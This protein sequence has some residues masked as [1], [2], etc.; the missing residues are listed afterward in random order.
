MKETK[1]GRPEVHLAVHQR[2]AAAKRL[3]HR[4][5]GGEIPKARR[6]PCDRYVNELKPQTSR[7]VVLISDFLGVVN[8]C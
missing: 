1:N 8:K 3:H 5:E 4:S 6:F 7:D 2:P